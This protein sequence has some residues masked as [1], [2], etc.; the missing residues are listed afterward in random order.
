MSASITESLVGERL[1]LRRLHLAVAESCTG[2]LL[3]NR[4]TN[5]PGASEYFLGGV[6]AYAYEAKVGMLDVSWETLERYG[7][8]SEQTV[9]EMARGAR[10]RLGAEVG[11]SVSG[12]AGPGGG[13]QEKPVGLVWIGLCAPDLERA[14]VYRFKGDRLQIKEQ[15]TEQALR[16]LA[17]YLSAVNEGGREQMEAVEVNFRYDV[18]GRPIPVNFTWQGQVYPVEST[19]RRWKDDAGEHILVMVPGEKVYELLHAEDEMRW[20]LQPIGSG[21]RFA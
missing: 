5:I 14:R 6:I 11:L 18:Q 21:S 3:C 7:A 12:I 1:R 8:V 4:I 20:Y 17:D 9:L 15:S 10:Q 2:G 19:G 16:L 13:T